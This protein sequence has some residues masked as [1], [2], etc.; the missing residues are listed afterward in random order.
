M[1]TAVAV[2]KLKPGADRV[3]VA[4]RGGLYL[5][6]QKSGVKSWAFRGRING[7]PVKLTLGQYPA[8]DLI[9]ARCL[10]ASAHASARAGRV[11]VP[12]PPEG[13]PEAAVVGRSVSE[14]WE[15]YRKL[16]LAVECR[17][18]TVSEHCRA[19]AAHIEPVLGGRDIAKVSKA[20]CL[21]IASIPLSTY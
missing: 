20:D 2:R 8:L 4:D 7:K 21:R 18:T 1:L 15:Q 9:A 12:P 16:R 5:V 3:E 6:I 10:A 13:A 17:E 19:F 14:V 11:F